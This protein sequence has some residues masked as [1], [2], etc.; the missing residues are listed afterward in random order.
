VKHLY[1]LRHAKSSW[2][3][4]SIEDHYRPLAPRGRRASELIAEHLRRERIEPSLVLCSSAL[5]TRQ[6]LERVLPGL[7]PDRVRVEH[8]LYGASAAQLLARLREVPS[9][10]A[11]VMLVGHQPAIQEL[12]LGLAEGGP[13]LD[14]VREKFPTAAM[15]TLEL[16]GD[17][18]GL[19]AG[20]GELVAY[21]RPKELKGSVPSEH[22]GGADGRA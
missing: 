16:A 3:D 9:D 2:D 13:Q 22:R 21:V 14:R 12:A 5:R 18:G 4:P 6:T 20:V 17:W 19:D 15:A 1:L 10:V 8:D 7:D 11:S